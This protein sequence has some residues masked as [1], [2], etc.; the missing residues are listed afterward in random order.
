[1]DFMEDLFWKKL[2]KPSSIA[3][4]DWR[5]MSSNPFLKKEMIL[6]VPHGDWD[7]RLLSRVG[8][9][10][11]LILLYPWKNWDW[12]YLS[13]QLPFS[14]I[15]KHPDLPWDLRMIWKRFEKQPHPNSPL[16]RWNSLS[17]EYPLEFILKHRSFPWNWKLVSRNTSLTMNDV[18]N[19][20]RYSWDFSYIMKHVYF[21]STDLRRTNR[22][23][24]DFKLLSENPYCRPSIVS[25]LPFKDW[26]WTKLAS[27]PAFPPNKIANNQILAPRWRWD[28]CLSNPRLTLDFYETIRRTVNI[29]K[30]FSQ[31]SQNHFHKSTQLLPYQLSVLVRFLW[32]T[33]NKKKIMYK[34]KLILV[35]KHSMEPDILQDILFLYMG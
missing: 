2:Q 33:Y 34:L 14:F 21:S 3:K 35:L 17:Q 10:A 19:F 8:W 24:F 15:R 16:F 11:D 27:H 30:H 18:C 22:L 32:L 13:H 28:R 12:G 6:I 5:A 9:C 23:K 26:D 4:N 7:W 25:I 20:S 31:L 29:P 1:M